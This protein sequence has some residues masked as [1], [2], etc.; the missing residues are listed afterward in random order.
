MTHLALALALA[1]A[2]YM[3]DDAPTAGR[4]RWCGA[5]ALGALFALLGAY[6]GAGSAR[7]PFAGMDWILAFAVL[8]FVLATLAASRESSRSRLTHHRLFAFAWRNALAVLL[9]AALT[10]VF[11]TLLWA[12]AW[13][14]ESIGL[15]GVRRL[16]TTQ[17]FLFTVTAS[18]FGVGM[19]AVLGRADTFAAVRR[20]WWALNPVRAARAGLRSGLAGGAGLLLRA[21]AVRHAQCRVLPVLVLRAV[22]TVRQHGVPGR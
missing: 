14:M 16:I 13:L 7:F 8:G 6:A 5:L 12:A 2:W 19:G 15:T 20:F 17:P 1:L 3:S 21:A 10:A 18:A 22:R 4:A 11:W 9:A